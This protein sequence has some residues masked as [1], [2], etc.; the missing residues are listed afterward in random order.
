MKKIVCYGSGDETLQVIRKAAEEL[1]VQVFLIS[2][3]CLDM[4]LGEVFDAEADL[5]GSADAF[6]HEYML[7]EGIEVEEL[8][9]LMRKIRSAGEEYEG[10]KVMRTETNQY[11]KLK[12]LFSHT[13]EEH[14]TVQ[15]ARVL[16]QILK[17]TNDIDIAKLAEEEAAPL[18]EAMMA[19]YFLLKSGEYTAE[20]LDAA[21]AELMT[22][23]K[24]AHRKLS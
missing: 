13:A 1:G 23:L 11:W 22:A 7:A 20:Q 2:D 14:R 4:T 21:A 8:I 16:Q 18:K 6:E 9:S 3:A 12:D 10:I 19:S 5:P 24:N 15:K 17:S